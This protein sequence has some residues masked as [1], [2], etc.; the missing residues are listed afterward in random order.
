MQIYI[1]TLGDI[2]KIVFLEIMLVRHLWSNCAA[3][4]SNSSKFICLYPFFS[5]GFPCCS[6]SSELFLQ[7]RHHR[8][9]QYIPHRSKTLHSKIITSEV[10]RVANTPIFR[11]GMKWTLAR[12]SCTFKSIKH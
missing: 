9:C 2:T 7:Q 6:M 3:S 10:Q 4:Q 12:F 1:V 8:L 5:F 11:L